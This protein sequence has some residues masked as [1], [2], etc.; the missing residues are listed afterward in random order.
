[1]RR[2]SCFCHCHT[3]VKCPYK[4]ELSQGNLSNSCKLQIAFKSQRKLS[5]DFRFKDRLPFDL[6]SGVVYRYT[7]GRCNSTYYGETDRHLKVMSGEHIGISP[8][9]LRKLNH[10]RK[11]QFRTMFWIAITSRLLRSLPFSQTGIT[12]SFLKSKKVCLSNEID[13]FWIKTLVLLNCF[14]LTIVSFLIVSL[15]SN[16]V[17]L[18]YLIV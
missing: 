1:M 18:W 2:K 17:W 4:L 13:L 15:Y 5:N 12:N 6:V 3:L 8:R 7:C 14:F 11:A 16:I 9:H 10:Q